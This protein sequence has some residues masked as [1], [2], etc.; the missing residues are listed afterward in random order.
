VG[1]TVSPPVRLIVGA[2]VGIDAGNSV[3]I[4]IGRV[5]CA[6]FGPVVGAAAGLVVEGENVPSGTRS[7]VHLSNVA[8]GTLLLDTD[9]DPVC[10]NGVIASGVFENPATTSV[11]V[12]DSR[13]ESVG[14]AARSD[15]G[16]K[17]SPVLLADGLGVSA[18]PGSLDDESS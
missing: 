16:M 1:A 15:T 5:V 12:L 17:V 9:G 18:E 2:V 6:S 11:G 3:G 13:T 14:T 7:S 10:S 8:V 4:T